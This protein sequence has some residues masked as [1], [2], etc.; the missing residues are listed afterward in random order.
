MPAKNNMNITPIF[1]KK[2]GKNTKKNH[3]TTEK[4]YHT[5]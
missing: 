3:F 1:D 5:T 4:I 2:S